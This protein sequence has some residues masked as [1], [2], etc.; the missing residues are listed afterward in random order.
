MN[1]VK[2]PAT[3]TTPSLSLYHYR[4]CPYCAITRQVIESIGIKSAGIEVELRDTQL[5]PEYRSELIRQGGRA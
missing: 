5:H 4:A 1:P 3:S 2:Q